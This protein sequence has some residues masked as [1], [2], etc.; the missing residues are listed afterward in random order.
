MPYWLMQLLEHGG[1]ARYMN[2]AEDGSDG[3]SGEAS[4]PD[5]TTDSSD[6]DDADETNKP[7]SNKPSEAEAK[8]LKET[9][10]RKQRIKELEDELRQ[11]KEQFKDIDPE[12]VRQLLKE[13]ED[14]ESGFGLRY[15]SCQGCDSTGLAT[16]RSQAR[17]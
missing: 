9:M 10:K 1:H 13:R 5:E 2:E 14:A 6:S 11:T 12:H 17:L 16:S 3:S 7:K 8:L 4:E 15:G